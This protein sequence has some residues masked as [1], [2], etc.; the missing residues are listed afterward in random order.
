MHQAFTIGIFSLNAWR[1]LHT[2]PL[3]W[4]DAVSV[5]RDASAIVLR[6]SQCCD[7]PY[8]FAVLQFDGQQWVPVVEIV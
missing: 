5:V 7:Y 4:D 8:S 6:F 2:P 1:P 3:I